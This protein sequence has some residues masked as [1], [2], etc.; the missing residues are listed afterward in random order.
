M[1]W[2]KKLSHLLS[3]SKNPL[4]FL[5]E[6]CGETHTDLSFSFAL[7]ALITGWSQEELE[8]RVHFNDRPKTDLIVVDDKHFFIRCILE[9]PIRK[10]EECMTFGVWQTLSEENFFKYQSA[11]FSDDRANTETFSWH[12]PRISEYL[13]E[14]ENCHLISLGSTLL[15]RAPPLRPLVFINECDHPLYEDQKNGISQKKAL[16]IASDCVHSY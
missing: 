11:Y 13:W 7:P 4:E 10:S 14:D 2:S 9:I 8:N 1:T 16:K 15:W 5:C 3:K 12:T 6:E